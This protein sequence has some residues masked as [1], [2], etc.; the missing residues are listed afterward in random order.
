MA[1][2]GVSRATADI[3][4]LTVETWALGLDFIGRVAGKI[5]RRLTSIATCQRP[6]NWGNDLLASGD[7]PRA[8]KA[9]TRSLR[10]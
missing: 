10:L 7:Y 9:F 4:L 8:A 6:G 2:H 3:D 5:R 1:I